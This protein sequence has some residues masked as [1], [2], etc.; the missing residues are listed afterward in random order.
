[1]KEWASKGF[2]HLEATRKIH[3]AGSTRNG[4]DKSAMT[5]HDLKT[6]TRIRVEEI[7]TIRVK[8]RV[9]QL[10]GPKS[11]IQGTQSRIIPTPSPKMNGLGAVHKIGFERFNLSWELNSVCGI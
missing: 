9:H 3:S 7:E 10:P 1:M 2:P 8:L 6:Q 5:R 4:S 11:H